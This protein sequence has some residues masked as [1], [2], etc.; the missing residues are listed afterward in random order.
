MSD[1]KDVD[2]A[3]KIIKKNKGKKI[4]MQCIICYPTKQ[5]DTDL[6]VLNV[7]PSRKYPE[8]ILGFSDHTISDLNAIVAVGIGCIL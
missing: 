6:N 7:F 4:I 1:Q 8:F 2:I 3:A 5:H